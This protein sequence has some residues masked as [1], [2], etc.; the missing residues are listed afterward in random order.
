MDDDPDEEVAETDEP[1]AHLPIRL[2]GRA[3]WHT[4]AER[5]SWRASV[6]AAATAASL[7]YCAA[8]LTFHAERPL[9][10]LAE[11]SKKAGGKQHKQL[12]APAQQQQA[13]S[14]KGGSRRK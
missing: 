1:Q 9:Q 13:G 10:A 11:R 3:I 12:P 8:A 4:T 2:R 14:S 7:A 5:E 6:A